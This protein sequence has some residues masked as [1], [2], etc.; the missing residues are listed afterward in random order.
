MVEKRLVKMQQS[1]LFYSWLEKDDNG[2][3]D[4][5]A[6]VVGRILWLGCLFILYVFDFFGTESIPSPCS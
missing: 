2:D 4:D 3:D 1:A 6:A 5:A